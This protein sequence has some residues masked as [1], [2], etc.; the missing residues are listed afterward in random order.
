MQQGLKSTENEER[1][2]DDDGGKYGAGD[3]TGLVRIGVVLGANDA[4]VAALE[5][6][7]DCGEDEDSEYG[8]YDAVG[9]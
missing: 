5:E 9:A 7:A 6:G 2:V 1:S 4:V 3:G 8:D